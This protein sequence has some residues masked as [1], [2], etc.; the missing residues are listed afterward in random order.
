[1]KKTQKPKGGKKKV[2]VIVETLHYFVKI[3]NLLLK[4]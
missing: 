4:V 3:E 2:K 1:M